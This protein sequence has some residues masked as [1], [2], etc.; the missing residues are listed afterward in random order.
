MVLKQLRHKK[1]AKKIWVV[2]AILILPAFILWG[3]GSV[4]R[5]REES[6]YAGIIAGRKVSFEDYRDAVAAV[7]SEAI[8]RFGDNPAEIQKY[9]NLPQQAWM[10]LILLAEAKKRRIK[11]SD[12][13]VIETIQGY[14]FFQA[15]GQFDQNLYSQLLHYVF[16]SAPRVFEEQTRQTIILSK[17]YDK[18][19]S[20]I[21]LTE[22]GI[23]EEYKKANEELSVYYIES[24]PS[25]FTKG[26]N[27]DELQVKEY[28]AKNSLDFKQPLSF[29]VEYASIDPQGLNK[30]R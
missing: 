29:N 1:T 30:T 4:M 26:L 17:L 5:G 25:D 28:F 20:G 3:S 10:R 15:H 22:A 13:E 11:A 27:P 14:P 21:K 8:I 18:V 16:R 23:K 19:T 6:K 24:L 12:K 2:L 7:T 9:V